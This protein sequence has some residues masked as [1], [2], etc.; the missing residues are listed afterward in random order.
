MPYNLHNLLITLLY[1]EHVTFDNWCIHFQNKHKQISR[2]SIKIIPLTYQSIQTTLTVT[3]TLNGILLIISPSVFPVRWKIFIGKNVSTH[4]FHSLF[5]VQRFL[6]LHHH[7]L[8]FILKVC[9]FFIY[10]HLSI[11][12]GDFCLK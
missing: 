12:D 3:K 1:T 10:Y 11:I 7:R 9:W 4:Y 2:H 8:C 5:V 6:Y